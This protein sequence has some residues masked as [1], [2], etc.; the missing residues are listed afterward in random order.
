MLGSLNLKDRANAFDFRAAR[1][2]WIGPDKYIN[3]PE[4]PWGSKGLVEA[5][6]GRYDSGRGTPIDPAID[7][8]RQAKALWA[9]LELSVVERT[10]RSVGG[11]NAVLADVMAAWRAHNRL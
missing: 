9:G 8:Q 5:D 2:V 10:L 3:H 1:F 4:G 6:R 7:L 11:G